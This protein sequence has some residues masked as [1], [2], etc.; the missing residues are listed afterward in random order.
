MN[1]NEVWCGSILNERNCP[2]GWIQKAVEVKLPGCLFNCW[3]FMFSSVI[4]IFYSCVQL[5]W[6]IFSSKEL[7]WQKSLLPT[8]KIPT[9]LTYADSGLWLIIERM[10]QHQPLIAWPGAEGSVQVEKICIIHLLIHSTVKYFI[11]AWLSSGHCSKCWGG[12]RSCLHEVDIPVKELDT[13]NM[14]HTS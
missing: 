7:V 13:E 14:Y 8:G 6:C 3:L 1:G 4:H 11:T 9:L 5:A 2:E 10:S 12:M